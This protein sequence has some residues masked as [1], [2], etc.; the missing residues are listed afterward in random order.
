LTKLLHI[1]KNQNHKRR[2]KVLVEQKKN[3]FLGKVNTNFLAVSCYKA[4]GVGAGDGFCVRPEKRFPEKFS[5]TH[6]DVR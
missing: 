6:K 3:V 2:K 4:I 5:S 1:G